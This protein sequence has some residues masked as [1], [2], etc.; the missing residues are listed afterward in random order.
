[1]KAIIF[2]KD[3]FLIKLK[4]NN[5]CRYINQITLSTWNI[6]SSSQTFSKHLSRVSTNTCIKSRIPS[7]DSDESTQK[8]KY[9]VA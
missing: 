6:R 7:S 2:L 1:M 9:S 3:C 5:Y 4:L 8:T